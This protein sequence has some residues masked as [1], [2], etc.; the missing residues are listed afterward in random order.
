MMTKVDPLFVFIPLLLRFASE[1]FRAL[2]DICDEY[3]ANF[4]SDT[5]TETTSNSDTSEKYDRLDYALSPSI[6]WSN[7]CD[8]KDVD[9]NLYMRF[10]HSKTIE[11]ILSKHDRL[12]IALKNELPANASKA[13]L[14]SYATDLISDYI[15]EKLSAN[16][17]KAVR[18]KHLKKRT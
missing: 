13:T 2:D 14:M 6:N 7:I 3:N 10:S 9:G 4:I 18:E 5:G 1:K 15:P 12:M 11:W 8:T 17:K 16:F